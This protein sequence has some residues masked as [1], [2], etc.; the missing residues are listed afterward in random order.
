MG[1]IIRNPD[2]K[3]RDF[4]NHFESIEWKHA[5]D[6]SDLTVHYSH[7]YNDIDARSLTA[8]ETGL[9]LVLGQALLNV[10]S[11]FKIT[12]ETGKIEQHD[13]EVSLRQQL[14]N[15]TKIINWNKLQKCFSSKQTIA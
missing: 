3:R 15:N 11:P 12:A 1:D 5:T 14:N 2:L 7:S 13:L 8:A 9:G 10:N 4:S 6:E